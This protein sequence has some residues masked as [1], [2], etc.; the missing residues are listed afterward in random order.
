VGKKL[1]RC[2]VPF[3]PV[4][5]PPLGKALLTQPETKLVEYQDLDGMPCPTSE[6]EHTTREG[7]ALKALAA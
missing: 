7:I 6:D 5:E 4:P 3:R 1:R 2:P